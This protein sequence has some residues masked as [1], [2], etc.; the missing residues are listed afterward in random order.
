MGLQEG[1]DGTTYHVKDAIRVVRMYCDKVGLGVT[2]TPTYFVYT[3]GDEPGCIVGLI[4]YPRFP[5]H[6]DEIEK[7]ALALANLLMTRFSQQRCTIET[8]SKSFLLENEELCGT[9]S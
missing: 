6:V 4:N 1:Y 2:V 9:N 7:H 5:K 3:D 8:P